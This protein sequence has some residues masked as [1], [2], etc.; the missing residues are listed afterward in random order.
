[1]K[2][3]ETAVHRNVGIYEDLPK[4]PTFGEGDT[5]TEIAFSKNFSPK[6]ENH[7]LSIKGGGYC[8]TVWH[9]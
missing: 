3:I 9:L 5:M 7:L 8:H 2:D 1:M 6:N 4:G